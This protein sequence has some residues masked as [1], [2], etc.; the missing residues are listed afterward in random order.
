MAEPYPDDANGRVLRGMAASGADMAAQYAIDF[1]HLFP[2]LRAAEAF[3]R[4]AAAPGRRVERSEYDGRGGYYWQVRVVV[5]MAPTHAGITRVE[6][7]LGGLADSCGG[8]ADG[9]GVLA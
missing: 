9:W 3:E 8:C 2:D 5:R 1:E 6:R 4:A 7:E